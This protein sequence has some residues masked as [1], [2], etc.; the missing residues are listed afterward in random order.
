MRV[1]FFLFSQLGSSN[2]HLLR[3]IK[4]K[5]TIYQSSLLVSGG[6]ITCNSQVMFRMHCEQLSFA[7]SSLG[8]SEKLVDA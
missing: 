6:V 1:L 8:L 2:F 7:T 5:S 4:L 3:E